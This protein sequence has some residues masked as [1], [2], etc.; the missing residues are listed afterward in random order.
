MIEG[1]NGLLESKRQP[2]LPELR[3]FLKELLGEPKVSGRFIDE[4]RLRSRVYRLRFEVDGDVRSLVAKR[5]SLDRSQREQLVIRRWLPAV[6]LSQNGPP[7]LGVAA[8]RRGQYVWHVYEDLGTW[9]LDECDLDL[10]RLDAVRDRGFL[11]SLV[12]SPDP[13]RIEAAVKLIAEIHTR[14]AGHALLGECRLYGGDLGIYFYTSSVTDAIRSLESLRPLAVDLSSERLALRDRL[15]QRMYKLLDEQ[16]Y[17]AQV[18]QEYGGPDTLLHGD[19]SIKNILVFPTETGLQ[20]RLI[21]WDHTGVGPVSYDLSNFLVQFPIRDRDEI[22]DLYQE[23]M[24]QTGRCWPSVLDWNQLFDT[25]EF[26]RLANSVIWPAIAV[27][28]TQAEWA[29]DELALVE[30]WFEMLEPVLPLN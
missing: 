18:I 20:A 3:A 22:L 25:A 15:L 28:E 13:E 7:L 9:T 4:Q 11:S 21:D 6:S 5:F 8:E 26:A 2:G 12:I 23:A 29:F 19:L 27:L 1:L 10:G 30:E 16:S 17:R 14:F 24:G